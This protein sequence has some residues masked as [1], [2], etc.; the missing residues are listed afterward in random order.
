MDNNTEQDNSTYNVPNDEIISN[1]L[2][3]KLKL[4]NIPNHCQNSDYK[5]IH[6]FVKNYLSKYCN[7]SIVRDEIDID[8][9]RSQT[10]FYCTK[11]ETC[12]ASING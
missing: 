4:E 6:T 1:M 9:E 5:K 3:I 7:H 11:C 10:I 8:P 12:F 2:A